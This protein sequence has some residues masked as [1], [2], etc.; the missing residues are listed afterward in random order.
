[1][2]HFYVKQFNPPLVHQI[3]IAT[4]GHDMQCEEAPTPAS[5]IFPPPELLATHKQASNQQQA[6][7]SPTDF[8]QNVPPAT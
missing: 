2:Q 1:M 3:R 4:P 5:H 7:F 6:S 8:L